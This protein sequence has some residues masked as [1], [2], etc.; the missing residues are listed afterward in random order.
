MLD[1]RDRLEGLPEDVIHI[2]DSAPLAEVMEKLYSEYGI[3]SL[4]VEGGAEVL[5]SFIRDGLYDRI[6]VEKSARDIHG[7]VKA[8]LL[9]SGLTVETSVTTDG[10][11][12]TTY[13]KA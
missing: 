13:R 8:P 7:K 1:R 5:G 12:V 3:T 11:T 10:N 2:T 6:R 9:P 4:L